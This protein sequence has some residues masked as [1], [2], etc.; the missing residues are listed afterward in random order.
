MTTAMTITAASYGCMRFVTHTTTA[1]TI[2][3]ASYGCMRFVT[4]TTTAVTI[5][6]ASYGCMRFVTHTT[7]AV[8]ITAASYGNAQRDTLK[9]TTHISLFFGKTI[10]LENQFFEFTTTKQLSYM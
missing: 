10:H 3:A 2:T 1:V 6:A 5:T 8:T 7:T 9:N 4:H